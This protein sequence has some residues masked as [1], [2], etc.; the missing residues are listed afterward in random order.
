MNLNELYT[1]LYKYVA[2]GTEKIPF[3]ELM[4]GIYHDR[5][6]L[7][8]CNNHVLFVI[9][10]APIYPH[11]KEGRIIDKKGNILKNNDGS[12]PVYPNYQIVMPDPNEK[13]NKA[14]NKADCKLV[15]NACKK[16]SNSED[17]AKQLY[18]RIAN[19]VDI[20]P[21]IIVDIAESFNLLGEEIEAALVYTERDAQYRPVVFTSDSGRVVVMPHVN[22][23]STLSVEDA[24]EVGDLL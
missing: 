9:H 24:L 1:I 16:I 20:D 23:E 6:Y 8:A 21:K 12:I 18:I 2:D 17:S 5:G 13:A 19:V 22:V 10:C 11:E 4:K 3:A 7:V 14:L 15:V